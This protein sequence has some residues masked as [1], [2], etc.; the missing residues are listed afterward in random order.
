[1][2]EGGMIGEFGWDL[3]AA[4]SRTVASDGDVSLTVVVVEA[5]VGKVAAA[6]AAAAVAPVSVGMGPLLEASNR[7]SE[8]E[9]AAASPPAVLGKSFP[10][11]CFSLRT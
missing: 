5:V 3:F 4:S 1:M 7:P 2:E 6:V 10:L 8:L 9:E 11:L